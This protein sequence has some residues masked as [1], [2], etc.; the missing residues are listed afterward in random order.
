M[1]ELVQNIFIDGSI[2]AVMMSIPV[3]LGIALAAAAGAIA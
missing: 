1:S 2:I 3:I